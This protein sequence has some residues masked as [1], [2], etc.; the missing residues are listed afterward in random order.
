MMGAGTPAL[1]A[2]ACG[3]TGGHLFPGRAV[4]CELQAAGCD[5]LLFVS[6]KAVDLAAVRD[7]PADAVVALPA[8]ASGQGRTRAFLRGAGRSLQIARRVFR[9]RPPAAVLA[10]GGFAGVGPVLAGRLCG[11]KVFLH[12]A[13]SVAGRANRW[14]GWLARETFL[15]FPSAAHRLR[16]RRTRVAGMPVRRAFQ[17]RDPRESRLALGIHPDRPVLLVLG[18]SQGA[19]TLSEAVL[20]TL[21]SLAVFE[22]DLQYIHL[23]GLRDAGEVRRAYA[24]HKLTAVVEPF[25]THLEVAMSAATVAISR[26]GASSLA[27]LAAMRL[28]AVLVPYPWA[29]D[30]HQFFNA[31][32]FQEAG[33]ARLLSQDDAT[34]ERLLAEVRAL[35]RSPAGRDGMKDA[36][37]R[38]HQPDSAAR[39]AAFIREAI[40]TPAP[41]V[42]RG[43][44]P[45][46]L[47]VDC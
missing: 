11:A 3:G 2:V 39:I 34:P 20:A 13:N 19:S 6:D 1:V 17:P 16:L 36:L 25:M 35:L 37:A 14:L 29:A 21:P 9:H 46:H 28:P 27:E 26:A 33:A 4:A 7:L 44:Q 45:S 22:P 12:E 40:P 15:Y 42:A 38:R 18:G 31:R 41:P 10:M 47:A 5:T 23:T 24:Q 8:S 43:R 30:N 32:S